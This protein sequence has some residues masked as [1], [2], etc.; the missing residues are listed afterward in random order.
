MKNLII[1]FACTIVIGQ[2]DIATITMTGLHEAEYFDL[3]SKSVD[4][5]F[6]IFVA[7]HFH[8]NP[9]RSTR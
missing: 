4:E 7:N 9:I 6:R 1:I 8:W 5:T 3:K 2:K